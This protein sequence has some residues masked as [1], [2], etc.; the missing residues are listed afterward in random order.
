MR[1]TRETEIRAKADLESPQ[2][3]KE[4]RPRNSKRL[5][6]W[7]HEVLRGHLREGD[8][9]ID[10][11]VG[12]GHDTCWLATC[13][14]ETGRV[15]GFDLQEQAVA[16]TRRRLAEQGLDRR[17]TVYR[18]DHSRLLDRVP[19]TWQGTVRGVVFNLGYLPGGDKTFTTRPS[20]T[21]LAVEACATQLLA[22][23]GLLSILSYTGH[24]GGAEESDAVRR[25]AQRLAEGDYDV[26]CIASEP[27]SRGSTDGRPELFLVRRHDEDRRGG[28]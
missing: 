5:V 27:D 19:T 9:A 23:G 1:K 21:L 2:L 11:T 12:N 17:V 25:W 4:P 16:A 13:V 14:G 22:P 3:E 26:E 6:V 20:T 7:A 10:G 15:F 24:P 8:R 18:E 28:D